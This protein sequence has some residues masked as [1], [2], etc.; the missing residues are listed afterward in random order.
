MG[1]STVKKPLTNVTK[2]CIILMYNINLK[3]GIKMSKVQK[4]INLYP[5][6]WE[7]IEKYAKEENL[8]NSEFFR[9]LIAIYKLFK[10]VMEIYDIKFMK[11]GE[12]TGVKLSTSMIERQIAAYLTYEEIY[13][14]IDN[15][16]NGKV[17]TKFDKKN[18]LHNILSDLKLHLDDDLN[19][20]ELT[21]D[22]GRIDSNNIDGD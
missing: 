5:N 9:K 17:L 3:V 12:E 11:G 15:S 10:P 13:D 4:S 21:Y 1:A 8:S 18:M 19:P 6:E 14:S 2:W 16:E 22:L 20:L 7:F